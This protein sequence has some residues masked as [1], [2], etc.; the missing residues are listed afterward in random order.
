M[1]RVGYAGMLHEKKEVVQPEKWG[2]AHL[3]PHTGYVC[4]T[5]GRTAHRVSKGVAARISRHTR[6]WSPYSEPGS[7]SGFRRA[8]GP[9]HLDVD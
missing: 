2:G 8:S 3:P 4:N 9:M 7:C 1:G 6:F 5:P